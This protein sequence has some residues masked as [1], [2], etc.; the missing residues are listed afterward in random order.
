VIDPSEVQVVVLLCSWSS[1]STS[2]AGY[3]DKCGAYTCPPHQKTNDERTPVAFE[4]LAYR[5]AL[6]KFTNEFTLKNVGDRADFIA[7]FSEWLP[8]QRQ[9]A[10]EAGCKVIALKHPLSVY[11]MAEI[12][13]ISD[14][15]FAFVTRAFQSIENTRKRRKWAVVYGIQGARILYN[16]A[17]R[18][19]Q[20]MGLPY[21]SVP[22]EQFRESAEIRQLL[23]DYC[24][25]EP[26]EEQRA[27]ADAWLR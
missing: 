10:A 27:A 6:A 3:L 19:L 12:Y 26:N 7:W 5:N 2:V 16:T 17:W 13:A 4:P 25:L 23:L 15:K 1:G 9:K 24:G 14:C 21:V 8:K 11:L 18:T 22:Y 20:N